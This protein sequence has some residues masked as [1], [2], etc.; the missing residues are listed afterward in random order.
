MPVREHSVIGEAPRP[1]SEAQPL[2]ERLR[3]V[4]IVAWQDRNQLL[5]HSKPSVFDALLTPSDASLPLRG[6]FRYC[7]ASFGPIYD[8]RSALPASNR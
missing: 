3:N 5:V 2:E 8:T 6:R 7:F 4:E 1:E